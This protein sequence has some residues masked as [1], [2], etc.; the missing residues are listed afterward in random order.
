M[1][2][3]RIRPQCRRQ[4][5][6]G[7]FSAVVALL[8]FAGCS[9]SSPSTV[10]D[11][12][13][14]VQMVVSSEPTS[15]NP[16]IDHATSSNVLQAAII[17]PLVSVNGVTFK[18]TTSGLVTGWKQ[19]RPDTWDITLRSGVEFTDREPFD[20][21]AAAYSIMY[22]L[23]P[24]NNANAGFF[25]DIKSAVAIGADV[26]KVTTTVPDNAVPDLLASMW[27]FP[28]KY[29]QEVGAEAFGR[30]PVGTGPFELASWQPGVQITLVRNPHY[31]GGLAQAAKIV[32]SFASDEQTR[33]QLLESGKADLI[34]DLSPQS[35]AAVT[36]AGDKVDR[37][38]SLD[39]VDLFINPKAPALTSPAVRRALLES[40]SG[41]EIVKAVLAGQGTPN[42]YYF[43]PEFGIDGPGGATDYDPSAAKAALAGL[44]SKPV[45]S[46]YYPTD[47]FIDDTEVGEAVAGMLEAAGFTVKQEPTE[48]TELITLIFGEHIDGAFIVDAAP[49]T[50]AADTL[51]RS[52]FTT[53]GVV[54]YCAEARLNGLANEA[55]S[56][57]GDAQAHLYNVMQGDVQ[58]GEYCSVGLYDAEGIYGASPKLAGFVPAATDYIDFAKLAEG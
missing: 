9:S 6:M 12:N 57:S 33:I 4:K 16:G 51:V 54:K 8:A 15:L 10:S 43:N 24:A 48:L 18:P 41:Q 32:I 5:V 28:P 45:I 29:L 58:V 19:A 30:R 11:R 46:L 34:T 20:A 55:L 14:T 39:G 22:Q 42:R 3:G 47:D 27:A 56:L 25:S 17:E 35:I 36:A 40:V 26:V 23:V 49:R 7:I 44:S 50:P 38:L 53:N 1:K 13:S 52:N 2:T 21:Q 31:W 37:T